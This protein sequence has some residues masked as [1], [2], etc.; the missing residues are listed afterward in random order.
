MV[1]NM[2]LVYFG[3]TKFENDANRPKK[4]AILTPSPSLLSPIEFD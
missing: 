4:G 3:T 1:A 2:G